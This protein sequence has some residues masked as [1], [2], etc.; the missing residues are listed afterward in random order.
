MAHCNAAAR[1]FGNKSTYSSLQ[2][3]IMLGSPSGLQPKNATCPFFSLDF[4]RLPSLKTTRKSLNWCNFYLARFNSM[5]VADTINF[6]EI[7]MKES[8]PLATIQ[9]AV[10]EFLRGRA[11]VVLF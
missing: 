8:V 5:F 4:V 10:I 9:N 2:L 3:R 11:D 6:R 7:A 1:Q